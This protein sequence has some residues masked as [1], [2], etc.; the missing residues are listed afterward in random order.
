MLY[1]QE[2][3]CKTVSQSVCLPPDVTAFLRWSWIIFFMGNSPKMGDT[4][5]MSK[6]SSDG[7]P[8][9]RTRKK[10]VGGL[11][12]CSL[13]KGH[14]REDRS[15][16]G[17]WWARQWAP[18]QSHSSCSTSPAWPGCACHRYICAGWRCGVGSGVEKNKDEIINIYSGTG[19]I[20]FKEVLLVL[21]LKN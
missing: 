14:E 3:A 5:G 4:K 16:W 1:P 8:L 2:I 13:V 19:Q 21:I 17:R 20:R 18:G 9:Y 6:V 15:T 10:G 11:L 12:L 7:A